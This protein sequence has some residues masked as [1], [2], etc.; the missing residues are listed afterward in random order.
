VHEL[1]GSYRGAFGTGPLTMLV[2]AMN[3]RHDVHGFVWVTEALA[4]RAGRGFA[5]DVEWI[6]ELD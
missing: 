6:D 4:R 5:E 1:L 2:V 3:G